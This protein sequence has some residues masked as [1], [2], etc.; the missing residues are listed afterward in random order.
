MTYWVRV[1]DAKSGN[2][3]VEESILD[4]VVSDHVL[5]AMTCE[6]ADD[7]GLCKICDSEGARCHVMRW[8]APNTYKKYC[9][10]LWHDVFKPGSWKIEALV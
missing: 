8:I 7:L 9:P 3:I 6:S 1:K 10:V 5:D 2:R 4:G